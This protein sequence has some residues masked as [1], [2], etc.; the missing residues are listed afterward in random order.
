MKLKVPV[1]TKGSFRIVVGGDNGEGGAVTVRVDTEKV[2]GSDDDVRRSA[3]ES[4][5]S[6]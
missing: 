5:S 3:S 2:N 6:R 4:N 1:V